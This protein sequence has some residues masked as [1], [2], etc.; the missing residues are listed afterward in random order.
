MPGMMR[1]LGGERSE[2]EKQLA[3]LEHSLSGQVKGSTMVPDAFLGVPGAKLF[4]VTKHKVS[5]HDVDPEPPR[6]PSVGDGDRVKDDDS[7]PEAKKELNG[8]DVH[9][10][11][12]SPV[13]NSVKG[14]AD[15]GE[16]RGG[17]DHGEQDGTRSTT[18]TVDTLLSGRA[19]S[20][21]ERASE[22]KAGTETDPTSK[23][24]EEDPPVGEKAEEGV[25]RV[26]VRAVTELER[27]VFLSRER[28]LVLA[29]PEGT[30]DPGLVKSNHH[31]T[32]L[33]K[34]TFMRKD[35]TLVT[36]HYRTGL[37]PLLSSTDRVMEQARG[38]PRPKKAVPGLGYAWM[39]QNLVF[40]MGEVGVELGRQDIK[41]ILV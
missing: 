22:S 40:S 18:L 36:L 19:G 29:C 14:E 6:V 17:N 32:E 38:V 34:M 11:T 8:D 4:T 1:K 12:V 21:S 5:Y 2:A 31:L 9:L 30:A 15:V 16:E 37:P 23:V 41:S 33:V 3:L 39:G 27:R 26:R 28:I 20:E 24:S 10:T 7:S 25:D 35:P 13:S